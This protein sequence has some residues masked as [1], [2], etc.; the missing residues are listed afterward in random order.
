MLDDALNDDRLRESF[1]GTKDK[2]LRVAMYALAGVPLAQC[3][4][5]YGWPEQTAKALKHDNPE[6]FRR[7]LNQL[8]DAAFAHFQQGRVKL[9]ERIQSSCENAASVL[10]ASI[11]GKKQ[12]EDGST[13]TAERRRDALELLKLFKDL[14]SKKVDWTPATEEEVEVDEETAEAE[15][16]AASA[17]LEPPTPPGEETN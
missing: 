9:V 12:M 16:Y 8:S 6:L 10:E 3:D 1:P 14:T 13:I 2:V 7:A 11:A 17:G 15:R 4:R 5:D